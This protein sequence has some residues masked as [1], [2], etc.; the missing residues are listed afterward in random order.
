ML[1]LTEIPPAKP[2]ATM[3]SLCQLLGYAGPTSIVQCPVTRSTQM[4]DGA[5]PQCQ[6]PAVAQYSPR[7]IQENYPA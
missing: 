5:K 4:N 2:V 3:Q 6:H 7:H 1:V